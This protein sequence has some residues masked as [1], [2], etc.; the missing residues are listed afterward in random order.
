MEVG[1]RSVF[2]ITN[3]QPVNAAG[4]LISGS[5][6]EYGIVQP[7]NALLCRSVPHSAKHDVLVRRKLHMQR[8]GWELFWQAGCQIHNTRVRCTVNPHFCRALQ[9]LLLQARIRSSHRPSRHLVKSPFA[10]N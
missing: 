4:W 6:F 2:L 7:S 1:R 8:R 10:H 9:E 3:S 5:K